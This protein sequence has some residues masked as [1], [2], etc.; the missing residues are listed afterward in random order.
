MAEVNAYWR[1]DRPAEGFYADTLP[2]APAL[3]VRTFLPAGYE[4]RYAYPLVV[5]F[6]GAGDSEEQVLK[7][8][9]KLSRRNYIAI[10]LRGPQEL[11]ATDD[12]RPAF[13]WGADGSWDG[14]VEDYLMKA[15]D[16]TRRTYHVH[17]ERVY[18]AGVGEGATAAYR[19]G[20][21][22]PGRVAGVVALNG[23]MPR[24]AGAPLFTLP[25]ARQMRVL[26]AH[27]TKNADVPYSTAQRDYRLLYAAGADVKLVGYDTG[28]KLHADMFRDVNRW[29]MRTINAATDALVLD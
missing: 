7:L 27:G 5:L 6:H 18:L 10:G 1:T 14:A 29:I 21:A 13:G 17:S 12:G 28:G 4:P 3:P 9:P 15:V 23:S 26:I 25:A 20:L 24:P 19:A 22:L 2:A 8:A 16:Q 11:P